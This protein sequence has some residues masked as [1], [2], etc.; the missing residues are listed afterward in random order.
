MSFL[1]G[2]KNLLAFFMDILFVF[3]GI[4][5]IPASCAGALRHELLPTPV[6]VSFVMMAP[7]ALILTFDL[8][9]AV[10]NGEF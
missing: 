7:K 9:V 8:L 10:W 3:G 6:V 4:L 2:I 1:N 5:L